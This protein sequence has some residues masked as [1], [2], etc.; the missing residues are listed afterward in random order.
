MPHVEGLTEAEL[1]LRS[2]T[3]EEQVR[4]VIA[5]G[6]L[7]PDDQ[8]LFRAGDIQRVKL[9]EAFERSG[10]S[11]Q[12]I[13]RAIQAGHLSFSFVDL[14]FA[15]PVAYTGQTYR[16][17]CDQ[18]G[19][20]RDLVELI[21][22]AIGLPH[23]SMDD[24]VREDD[25]AMFPIGQFVLG[26]GMD[27]AN[28]GR[29]LRVY[30][31]NLR[32]LA[33][34]EPHFYHTYVEG[35]MLRSG[36]PEQQMRDLATQMNPQI[37]GLVE[38]LVIWLYRRHQEHY[39]T[40]HLIEHVES[41]LEEAGVAPRRPT[42]PP[43]MAFLDLAGYTRLTEEQGDEAAAELAASLGDLVQRAARGYG[44]Q[45]VKW[46]GD[47][48][49]FHFPDPGEAVRCSLELVDE[50]P[51]AGLPPAHVGVNSGPVI[52]RDGDYFG[53]TVNLASRIASRAGPGQVLVTDEVIANAQHREG[54][55]F[56]ELGPVQLKGVTNP[57][58]L[59]RAMR[60]S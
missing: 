23:P 42:R 36:M 8:G 29:V 9:A 15:E 26:L 49:M 34:A 31:E 40:E 28:I 45:P 32:R 56:K 44:G 2:G 25:A 48:V 27:A 7:S 21:H 43:A 4:R 13:G 19:L 24:L 11:L 47:G 3:T 54:L 60:A 57:V 38:R 35:P 58:V 10:I 53:R 5:V 55:A 30:G 59:H 51:S 37:T 14:L 6:I 50:A 46:L 20:S 1:A 17:M 22:E 52:V 18:Y 16:Q 33:Q 41:A 12:S 39:T